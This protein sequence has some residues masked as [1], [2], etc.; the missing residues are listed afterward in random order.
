MTIELLKWAVQKFSTKPQNELG[1]LPF[2]EVQYLQFMTAAANYRGDQEFPVSV[3]Q[4][5]KLKT[6]HTEAMGFKNQRNVSIPKGC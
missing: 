1:D 3:F 4:L 6:L 5:P 2:A